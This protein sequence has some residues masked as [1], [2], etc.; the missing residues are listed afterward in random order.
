MA[1]VL[2]QGLKANVLKHFEDNSLSH[3]NQDSSERGRSATYNEP[4]FKA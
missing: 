1:N 4:A 3:L 2:L